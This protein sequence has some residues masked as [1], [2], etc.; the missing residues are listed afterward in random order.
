MKDVV[1]HARIDK[2]VKDALERLKTKDSEMSVSRAVREALKVF[3]AR[4]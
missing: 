2:K 1:I 3:L 4:T